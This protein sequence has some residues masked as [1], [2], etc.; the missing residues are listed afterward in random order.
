MKYESS[1]YHHGVEK[2]RWGQR[3]GPPYPLSRKY[4][5]SDGSLTPA[6]EKRYEKEK[7]KNSLQKQKNQLSDAGVRDVNRWVKEDLEKKQQVVKT[8]SDMVRELQ[9]IERES[10]PKP[11]K[12]RM[13]L[14]GMSDQELRQR[15]NRELTERQYNDLFGKETKPAISKGREYIRNT[16]DVAG[17]VLAIG[18]SSLS[19]ALAIRALKG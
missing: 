3:N 11:K 1:L 9:K 10:S 4:Q 7:Y 6:G 17:S 2:M 5:K 8:S 15:I 12:E 13:D 14:S 18:S 16:L 19:I